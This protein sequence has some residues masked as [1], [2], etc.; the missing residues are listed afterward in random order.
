MGMFDTVNILCPK[1]G[2]IL[3]VQSKAAECTF[4]EYN[5]ATAPP[6]IAGDIH[7]RIIQCDKC[8]ETYRI[9]TQTI[10]SLTHP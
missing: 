10:I 7:N 5:V 4:A 8:N 1:C 6:A 9:V 3:D 2:H